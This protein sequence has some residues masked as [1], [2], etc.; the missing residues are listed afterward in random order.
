MNWGKPNLC[1][2]VEL[3]ATKATC[4]LRHFL[5]RQEVQL[6]KA[7]Y[8]YLVPLSYATPLYPEKCMIESERYYVTYSLEDF[9]NITSPPGASVSLAL[10]NGS[11]NSPFAELG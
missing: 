7:K 4:T 2:L 8:L 5:K 10:K 9:R 3:P 6:S 11:G 1:L